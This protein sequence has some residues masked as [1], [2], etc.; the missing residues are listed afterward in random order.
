MDRQSDRLSLKRRTKPRIAGENGDGSPTV[1]NFS[2]WKA[3]RPESASASMSFS[4][5]SSITSWPRSRST[6]ATAMP[7]KRCP[8]VPPHAITAFIVDC[9]ILVLNPRRCPNAHSRV[10]LVRWFKNALPIN[11]QQQTDPE[12]ASDQI[13]ASVT[14]KG[15]GQSFVWQE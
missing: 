10:L 12:H 5:T 3:A 13:R 6:S 15:Q 14:D 9:S 4:E 1:G 11:I 2:N 8:P 7:G